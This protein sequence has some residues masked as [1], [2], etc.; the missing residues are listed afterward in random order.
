MLPEQMKAMAELARNTLW[1]G[2]NSP[3]RLAKLHPPR[4]RDADLGAVKEAIVGMDLHYQSTTIRGP[5]RLHRQRGLQICSQRHQAPRTS[6]WPTSSS[7]RSNSTSRSTSTSPAARTP[8]P[9]TTS[10]TSA[11][12]HQGES[13]R[14]KGRG[15]LGRSRWRGRG[16]AGHRPRDFSPAPPFEDLKPL[17]QKVLQTYLEK[18]EGKETFWHFSRRHSADELKALEA[19]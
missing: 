18:R 2:G 11:A 9:S 6:S 14:G 17:L 8:A 5:G 1:T 10:A 13:W 19:A 16:A 4:D 15:L 7:R 3:H 12:R